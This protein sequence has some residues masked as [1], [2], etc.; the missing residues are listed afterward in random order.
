MKYKD[1]TIRIDVVFILG[2]VFLFGILGYKLWLISTHNVVEGSD[3]AA[4][5]KNRT[6]VTKKIPAHKITITGVNNLHTQSIVQAL[7][8]LFKRV[9]KNRS[10]T[11]V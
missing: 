6:T 3:L 4:I 2:I 9:P 11:I 10:D 8:F 1:N 5:A 7:Q